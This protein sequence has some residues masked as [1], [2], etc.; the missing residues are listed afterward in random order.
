MNGNKGTRNSNSYIG[1]IRLWVYA[2]FP[3]KLDN[4]CNKG[5]KTYQTTLFIYFL[6]FFLS[7]ERRSKAI[8]V[9]QHTQLHSY[10]TMLWVS[11]I[12]SVLQVSFIHRIHEWRNEFPVLPFPF[13][14]TVPDQPT[15]LVS[16]LCCAAPHAAVLVHRIVQSSLVYLVQLFIFKALSSFHHSTLSRMF[17]HACMHNCVVKVKRSGNLFQSQG[18]V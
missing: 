6:S 14:R 9:D 15:V 17:V 5:L 1:W 2:F 13:V 7:Y 10:R 11:I 8:H 3:M 12:P 4:F 16:L 18:R